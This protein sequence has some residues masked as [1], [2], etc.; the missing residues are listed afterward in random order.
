MRNTKYKYSIGMSPDL[1]LGVELMRVN[2]L[3][4]SL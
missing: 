2:W 4:K 1:T 3:K